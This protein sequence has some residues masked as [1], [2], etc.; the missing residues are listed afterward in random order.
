[1]DYGNVSSLTWSTE[2]EN[3]NTVDQQQ[4]IQRESQD[5]Y[6]NELWFQKPK[7]LSERYSTQWIPTQ[8]TSEQSRKLKD[9]VNKIPFEPQLS[10]KS[11][12]SSLDISSL[13]IP[14]GEILA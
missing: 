11:R 3:C 13:T 10:L 5:S 9:L 1:M 8:K 2:W 7:V 4:V 14:F 6:I 12:T